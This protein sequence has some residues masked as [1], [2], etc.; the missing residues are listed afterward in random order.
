[1]SCAAFVSSALHFACTDASLLGL[2][3][4]PI[5]T[6][7]TGWETVQHLRKPQPGMNPR[8]SLRSSMDVAAALR[9]GAVVEAA[10]L[11][12]NASRVHIMHDA[13]ESGLGRDCWLWR[14]L[15]RCLLK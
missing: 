13:G 3:A 4:D 11:S 7:S 1:M 9:S 14:L 10:I 8:S 5:A 12:S 15:H 2:S 6:T